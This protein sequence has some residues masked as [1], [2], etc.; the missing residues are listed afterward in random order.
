MNLSMQYLYIPVYSPIN[1]PIT[2][3]AGLADLF[4]NLLM[5]SISGLRK[6]HNMDAWNKV[7]G[8]IKAFQAVRRWALELVE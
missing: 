3:A 6:D 8:S 1:E 4:P 7:S 5:L 2:V